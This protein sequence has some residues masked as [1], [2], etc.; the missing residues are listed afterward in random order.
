MW[1][2]KQGEI[3][4]YM[5]EGSCYDAQYIGQIPKIEL[6]ESRYHYDP[7]MITSDL[8]CDVL[9]DEGTCIQS[10]CEWSGYPEKYCHRNF[11]VSGLNPGDK[12]NTFRNVS[13]IKNISYD[14]AVFLDGSV[15]W[16]K[17]SPDVNNSDDSEGNNEGNNEGIMVKKREYLNIEPFQ[18]CPNAADQ[19]ELVRKLH[20]DVL[21]LSGRDKILLSDIKGGEL[22]DKIK[23][24]PG[25]LPY[26]KRTI[27]TD[28]IER[29]YRLFKQGPTLCVYRAASIDIDPRIDHLI[30]PIPASTTISYEFAA[31]W[32]KHRCYP[33]IIKMQVDTYLAIDD[34][35]AKDTQAEVLIPAGV[36]RISCVYDTEINGLRATVVEGELQP[37]GL[38]Q[39][40]QYVRDHAF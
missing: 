32:I 14:H 38:K 16:A 28:L 11:D 3:V 4:S 8:D 35:T 12:V 34:P 24:G 37:W 27:N 15:R 26:V 7:T 20:Q 40:L 30:V 36:I 33:C 9:Q 25:G 19:I 13:T 6:E 29:V 39:S 22:M 17:L 10:K 2:P 5:T 18:E 1:A 31:Q 23:T 21:K